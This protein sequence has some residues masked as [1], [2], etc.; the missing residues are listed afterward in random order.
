MVESAQRGWCRDSLQILV[1]RD[2]SGVARAIFPLVITS[3]GPGPLSVRKLRPCGSVR[4]CN[5][6]EIPTP[7][8]WPGFED[9]C[10]GELLWTLESADS[11]FHWCDLLIRGSR[12]SF[13]F[14][15]CAGGSRRCPGQRS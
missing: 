7:L 12:P 5:L 3:L 13:G 4:R 1:Q 10:V 6:T 15:R 8:V 2:A 14:S 9:D 11:R